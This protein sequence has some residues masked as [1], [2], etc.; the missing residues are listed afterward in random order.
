M[1]GIVGGPATYARELVA[2]LVGQG[3]HEYVVFTDRPELFE[4][5]V[6]AVHVPLRTTYGQVTWD[7]VRLPGLLATER[8][9]LYH[10]TKN[11]LPWRLHVPAVVTVHDLAVYA[12]PD[13][14][15]WPQ[16]WHFQTFVPR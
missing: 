2:A 9:D 13:T 10:G 4:G 16:R 7:H 14:F 8:V 12:H 11:I 15:A 3:G 1:L 5:D 6:K